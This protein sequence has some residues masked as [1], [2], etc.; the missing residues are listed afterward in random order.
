MTTDTYDSL[1]KHPF[2][3]EVFKVGIEINKEI[4]KPNGFK[5]GAEYKRDPTEAEFYC[6]QLGF[7]LAHLLTVI[8]QMEHTVLYMSNFSPS[9]LMK[10]AGVTRSTH[11]LW[12]VENYIVRTQT[13]YD[14]LLVLVDRLFHIQNQPNR[15]SHESIVTNTHISQTTIPAAL[16]PVKSAIKKYYHDRNTIIHEASYLDDELRRIEAYTILSSNPDYDETGIRDIN[17]EVK[18]LV[19][20]FLKKRKAEFSKINKNV[21]ITLDSLFRQMHPIYTKKY[22]QLRAS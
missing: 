21:C 6:L 4:V 20:E 18:W 8:Q 17:E 22:S 13:V 7:C 12:S 3:E 15:I 10:K 14:R 16:K 11:L 2:V 19:R 1:S 9:D 5:V